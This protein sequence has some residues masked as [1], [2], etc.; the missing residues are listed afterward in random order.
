[1]V[2]SFGAVADFLGDAENP[3]HTVWNATA[4]KLTENWVNPSAALR[5]I[6]FSL[7]QLQSLLGEQVEQEDPDALIDFFSL[8]ISGPERR[9]GDAEPAKRR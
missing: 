5:S 8:W 9:V 1:M 2:A 3:A 7:K 6:R 4:E